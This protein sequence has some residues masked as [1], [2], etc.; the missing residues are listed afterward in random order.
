MIEDL[1]EKTSEQI[2]NFFFFLKLEGGGGHR[3]DGWRISRMS[4]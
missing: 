3:S 2:E 4:R 1:S